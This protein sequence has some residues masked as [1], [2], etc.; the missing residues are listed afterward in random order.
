MDITYEKLEDGTIRE[1][2]TQ[3]ALVSDKI[4]TVD[5]YFARILAI[6]DKITTLKAEIA[7][8]EKILDDNAIVIPADVATVI[9]E[10]KP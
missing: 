8:L 7:A 3:V 1:I 5:D 10:Q 9:D 6:N 4:K 2:V